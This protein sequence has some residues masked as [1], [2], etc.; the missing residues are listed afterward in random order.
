MT[1]SGVA[2]DPGALEC[3]RGAA[4]P[5]IHRIASG[6][7]IG[8]AHRRNDLFLGPDPDQMVSLYFT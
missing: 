1:E 2:L 8:I 4:H 6:G 7:G 3:D 5:D